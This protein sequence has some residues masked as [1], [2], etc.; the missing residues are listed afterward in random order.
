[1]PENSNNKI[2][3]SNSCFDDIKHTL[4]DMQ[5]AISAIYALAAKG[6]PKKIAGGRLFDRELEQ[7]CADPLYLDGFG[8]KVFS[9]ND[10]DGII[11]EIFSRIG[12][13]S[14]RFIEFGVQNGLETNTR[15]LLNTGWKGLW[16]EG[17]EAWV[18]DAG[19]RFYTSI[20]E[21]NLRIHHAFITRDNINN[22]FETCGIVG[23]I[24]FLSVDID[25]NDWHVLKEILGAQLIQPRVICAEYNALLPPAD[26]PNDTSTDW[27]M[28]YTPEWRWVGDDCQGASLSAYYHLLRNYG[29]RI[30]GTSTAGI[31]AFFVRQDVVESSEKKANRKLFASD[32]NGARPFYNPFRF[33]QQQY[34]TP[35]HGSIVNIRESMEHRI[36]VY[37]RMKLL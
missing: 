6:L 20:Q 37:K 22:L 30:V 26:D 16:I 13:T 3:D 15:L 29:F 18:R 25:G 21:G 10:E 24:D 4:T 31:N 27:V 32:S 7:R 19:E 14:K 5:K 23:P 2:I 1:M 36:E 8:Y 33:V 11:H 17:S 9:Q 12:T 35:F 34:V 28:E